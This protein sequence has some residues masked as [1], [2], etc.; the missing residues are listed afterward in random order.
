MAGFW[1]LE[2]EEDDPVKTLSSSISEEMVLE[3][4]VSSRVNLRQVGSDAAWR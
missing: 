3:V 1:V 4:A 2:M